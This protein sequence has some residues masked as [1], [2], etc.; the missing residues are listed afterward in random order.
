MATLNELQARLE[1]AAAAAET[2]RVEILRIEADLGR[3][4]ISDLGSIPRLEQE[5]AAVTARRAAAEADAFRTRVELLGLRE[6]GEDPVAAL[7]G[8]HP[9]ALLPVR[10]ETRFVGDAGQR[11]LLVRVYPDELHVD[12]HEP[13][14][15]P[16]ELDA[17]RLY[18]ERLWRAGT[19]DP[20]AERA[21]FV[22]LARILEPRRAAWVAHVTAPDQATRPAAPT[23][24]DQPL[25]IPPILATVAASPATMNRPAHT[26]VLPDRWIV[27]GYR[28]ATQTTRAIGRIIPDP[29]QVGPAPD[30]GEPIAGEPLEPAL[31]WL[32]DFAEAERVGMG[33]RIP[34]ADELGFDRLLVLGVRSSLDP[35][36]AAARLT[37]L[38]DA[39][40]Y[41]DGFA[42]VPPGTPT[43]N[44]DSARSGW[45]A[46]P[47]AEELVALARALPGGANSNA[48][49]AAEALGIDPAALHGAEHAADADQADAREMR[50]A[51]WPA[52]LGYFLETMLAPRV[53]DADVEAVREQF[54]NH[55]RG[56]GPL[57]ALRIGSQPY[58]L[59]P[60]TAI[61]RWRPDPGDAAS[62]LRIVGLLRQTAPEWLTRTRA[63]APSGV[64]RVGRPGSQPDAEMLAIF[65]RDALSLGY[66][67][68]ALRGPAFAR[69]AATLLGSPDPAGADLVGAAFALLD[70][71]DLQVRIR[72]VQFD[73]RT[74]RIQRPLVHHAP[75]SETEPVPAPAGGTVPNYL[76]WLADRRERSEDYPGSDRN[77]ILYALAR[78]GAQ[79]ADADAAVRFEAQENVATRKTALEPEL[80]D[81]STT[82]AVSPTLGRVLAQPVSAVSA[83]AIVSTKSVG[84]YLAT[85]SRAE[86]AALG[87][88]HVLHGFDRSFFVRLALR[89]LSSRP[90]AVIDRLTREVLDTCSHRLDAWITSYATRR[91]DRMRTQ[92]PTGIHLGGYAWVEDLRPKP[93]P[94]PVATLPR[95]ER[96][97]LFEDVT[98]AGFV[99]APSLGHAAAAAVL[100]SGH[101][102]HA[103]AGDP[104]GPLAIDLSSE[105]VRVAR[106][107]IDGVRQGQPLG[108][109]LGYR[110]ERGLHDR[111]RAGLNLDRFIRRFRALAPLVAGR[112]EPAQE[113]VG[114]VEAVAANNVADGLVLLRRVSENAAS[115]GPA[116]QAQP[117]ATAAERQAIE[118]ELAAL[119]D[120]V[121]A[122]AD[123]LL[124]EATYQL[125]DG[126]PTRAAATVDALGSGL[127]PPPELEITTTPRHGWAYT[128]RVLSLIGAGTSPAA[129]WEASANR[130]RRRA[131]PRLDRWAGTL[132][133]PAGRIRAAAA[134]TPPGGGQ[135]R[136]R[137]LD[138]DATGLCALD[139]VYDTRGTT[140]TVE[141]WIVDAIARAP[142]AGVRAGTTVR[143][144]HAGDDGWPGAGWPDDVL[145]LEDALAVAATLHEVI[146]R[147]RPVTGPELMHAGA[148]VA[149]TVDTAELAARASATRTAFDRART[150]LGTAVTAAG[151]T[152]TRARFAA[153]RAALATLAGFGVAA[154]L[155]AARTVTGPQVDDPDGDGRTL[156]AAAALAEQELRAID[157]RITSAGPDPAAQLRALLGERFVVA[158]LFAA[159]DAGA[160]E[161]AIAAGERP[162]FLDGDPG[163]PLAWLQRA[164]RV[165]ESV[166]RLT[167][168][169]LYG[170]ARTRVQVAQLP[171]ADHWVALPLGS[172][173]PPP[174]ATSLVIH[175]AEPVDV[176]AKAAGLLVDEWTDVIPARTVTTGLSF[177]FDEPGARA[178]HAILLAV[179]PAPV[180]RWSLDVLAAVVHETADLARIRMVG[181]E[182][183]PWFGR[184]VPALYFADNRSGDTLHVDFGELVRSV[185]T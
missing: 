182:E 27:I 157:A 37:A 32:V 34:V 41:S 168:G 147:S 123:V 17:A 136:V 143:I 8:G 124:A 62:H 177:N 92:N 59:L 121:D 117:A 3:A 180:E 4:R 166:G 130:P 178:P 24:D 23:P 112:R 179:P 29:L 129:G 53:A 15:T 91:L 134:L 56:L 57:P 95:G 7:D 73:P 149:T 18:W 25:P 78:H 48:V 173:E 38:F 164:G 100:R 119:G 84:D 142:G 11:S 183:T 118:A 116:L 98:N 174:A 64:P 131:E 52:T 108:A 61:S 140:S 167:L 42:F 49:V 20:D 96:G 114:A 99:H 66:R 133:G 111:S 110:F 63:A 30:L 65:A 176:R 102:S 128:N 68:R 58:G 28:G 13:E 185:A 122:I 125:I 45:D 137:E 88:P 153:V 43:N 51:L 77:T 83:G 47:S 165:R 72:G 9:I 80:V 50:V 104:D 94:T 67:V 115:I 5:L 19:T 127:G 74:S 150:A 97:P 55:V 54:V 35:A 79:L 151:G 175:L 169:L 33:I 113:T 14:L 103:R 145:P 82:G 26:T 1:A 155:E 135:P 109:L 101:L 159:P 106:W 146:V 89:R 126:S 46:L 172:R 161:T 171:E 2:S 184:I 156:L 139:L 85:T 148:T 120:A 44:T 162:A 160:L 107:L 141:Q 158:P 36:A 40:R 154:G 90:S 60:T 93:P 163:A 16:E 10:I 132:L 69:T 138:L 12:T 71:A 86:V 152:P 22:E 181:P 76:R 31:R 6:L 21:A 105:R 81:P 70:E 144:L 170:S 87:V 75:P 39:H